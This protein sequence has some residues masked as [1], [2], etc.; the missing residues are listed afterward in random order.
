MPT[1]KRSLDDE[2]VH[3]AQDYDD[4]G[5]HW[6]QNNKFVKNALPGY[7]KAPEK[8]IGLSDPQPDWTFGLKQAPNPDPKNRR[9]PSKVASLLGVCPS[10]HHPFLVIETKS[11]EGIGPAENQAIRDGSTIV[12]APRQL[13][14]IAQARVAN[15]SHLPATYSSPRR[16]FLCLLMLLE[17]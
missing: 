7:S 6:I 4:D 1:K 15:V 9:L 5:L 11:A 12:N 16:A 2:V 8:A 14:Y 10:M 17:P 13:N 3:T